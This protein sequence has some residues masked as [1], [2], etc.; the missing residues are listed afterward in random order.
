MDEMKQNMDDAMAK[1][2]ED[3]VRMVSVNDAHA[4]TAA[5]AV[6]PEPALSEVEGAKPGATPR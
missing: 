1:N 2:A 4:G 5:S 3:R 6:P